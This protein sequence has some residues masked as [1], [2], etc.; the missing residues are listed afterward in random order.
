MY[1]MLTVMMMMMITIRRRIVIIIIIIIIII[2]I[3]PT[4]RN[5]VQVEVFRKHG[6]IL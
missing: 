6:L 5:P 4:A 3:F 1:C 2:N